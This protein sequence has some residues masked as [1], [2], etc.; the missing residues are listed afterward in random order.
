MIKKCHTCNKI[1]FLK[2][3]KYNDNFYCNLCLNLRKEYDLK[4]QK[5]NELKILKEKQ[6]KAKLKNKI[7]DQK[8][9]EKLEKEKLNPIKKKRYK[10][11][12]KKE[13]EKINKSNKKIREEIF[14]KN[15]INKYSRLLYIKFDLKQI[16]IIDFFEGKKKI[17]LN[18]KREVR[19]THA[20]GF[21]AEKFQKFVDAKKNTTFDWIIEQISKPG[22]I[23]KPY[24]II[25]IESKYD[26][27]K[28]SLEKYIKE[29]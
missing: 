15:T 21:S 3:V 4:Q 13:F 27:I 28:N 19:K 12:E 18:K 25:K 20:G 29:M 9:K 23:R 7:A 10:K 8:L 17:M 11:I 2:Y 24:D 26:D 22:I 6:E 5:I 14:D 16:L 1:L